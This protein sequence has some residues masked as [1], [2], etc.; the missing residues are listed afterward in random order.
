MRKPKVSSREKV[1]VREFVSNAIPTTLV[2]DKIV[3]GVRRF[4]IAIGT[5][6][7]P[8]AGEF[9]L[10]IEGDMHRVSVVPGSPY[11][12]VVPST[13]LAKFYSLVSRG[14]K[15]VYRASFWTRLKNWF[16]K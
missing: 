12:I 15:P 5:Q 4:T 11:L 9:Y 3:D 10:E 6:C 13:P 8:T 14:K 2:E 16:Y 7:W 1:E